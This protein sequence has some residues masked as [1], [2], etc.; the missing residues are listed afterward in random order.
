MEFFLVKGG[1]L[2]GERLGG[3][4]VKKDSSSFSMAPLLMYTRNVIQVPA[5]G[6]EKG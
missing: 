3:R 1:K 4:E 5:G 2:E 6:R